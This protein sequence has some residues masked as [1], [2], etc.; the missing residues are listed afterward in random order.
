MGLTIQSI[1]RFIVKSK[2]VYLS[3]TYT[4]CR[5]YP[6]MLLLLYWNLLFYLIL[7]AAL[8][9]ASSARIEWRASHKRMKATS[10]RQAANSMWKLKPVIN[11]WLNTP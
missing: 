3:Y 1:N 7:S 5:I 6:L 10:G 11:T 4:I 8:T 9:K 2:S